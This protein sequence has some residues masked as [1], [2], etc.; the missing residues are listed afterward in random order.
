MR[1]PVLE[2]VCVHTQTHTQANGKQDAAIDKCALSR[3]LGAL[4]LSSPPFQVGTICFRGFRLS[5]LANCSQRIRI[6]TARSSPQLVPLSSHQVL[7]IVC[8][9]FHALAHSSW[10][11]GAEP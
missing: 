1:V 8:G 5:G 7:A 4:F 11:A 9:A 10:P 6:S 3:V 2:N